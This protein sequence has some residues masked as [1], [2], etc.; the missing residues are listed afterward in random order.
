M[1]GSCRPG[2]GRAGAD[3]DYPV[4]G[5]APVCTH[6]VDLKP[7]AREAASAIILKRCSL[8]VAALLLLTDIGTHILRAKASV[9][10]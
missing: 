1:E 2:G 8:T 9:D 10:V 4:L 7:L 6:V 3:S 5:L